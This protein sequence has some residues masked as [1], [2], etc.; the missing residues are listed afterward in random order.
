MA[1]DHTRRRRHLLFAGSLVALLLAAL[2]LPPLININR[3]QRQIT[4]SLA[5]SLGRPVEVSG[6]RLHLLPRPAVEIGNFIIDSTPGFGAEPILQ[7]SSVTADLRLTSLWRGRLEIARISLDEPS[8]N[9]ERASSGEWNFT[10]VLMQASRISQ[11]PTGRQLAVG[12]RRFPYIEASSARINF[13]YGNEKLPFSF[14]NADVSIWL[15]RPDEWQLR[16]AAQPVRTDIHLSLA[17]TGLVQLTGS[18]RRASS[19]A[20]LPLDL[21]LEWRKAPLGQVSRML[22]AQDLGWRGD[23]GVRA[24]ITGTPQSL[25]LDAS[26]AANDFHRESF[27]P[28]HPMNLHVRCTAT[29][30]HAVGALEG[31]NCL[32]PVGDG[33]LD[34]SGS[35][36]QLHMASPV[37]D[38]KLTASH[39]PAAAALQ[40]LRHTRGRLSDTITLDGTI[41][42]LLIYG[43]PPPRMGMRAGGAAHGIASGGLLATKLILH[44]DDFEQPLPDLRFTL[45]PSTPATLLLQPARLELGAPQPLLAD[46]RLNAQGFQLHYSG[47]A[48]LARLLP[49]TRAFGVLP[50]AFHGLGDTGV[51]DY[52]LTLQGPW[53]P[54]LTDGETPAPA[55]ATSG[56]LSLRDVDFQPDYLPAPVHIVTATATVAPDELRWTGIAATLGDTRFSGSLRMPLP[57]RS[58]CVRHFDLS[59][60]DTNMGELTALLRGD[61]QGVMRELISRVRTQNHTWPALEGSLH[62]GRLGLGRIVINGAVADLTA[63]KGRLEMR[64][65]DGRVLGG[66]VHLTGAA[67]LDA[68]PSYRIKLQFAHIS[69]PELSQLMAEHW[70]P[71]LLDI[72]GNL[73]LSGTTPADLSSSA[74]GT[75]HWEWTNGALPLLTTSPLRRFDRWTG[76]GKVAKGSLTLTESRIVSNGVAVPVTGTI[77]SDRSLDLQ[78]GSSGTSAPG[79]AVTGSLVAPVAEARSRSSE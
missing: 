67:T 56:S 1:A 30:R 12:Q 52:N 26:A 46:A 24:H 4:A 20:G 49:L 32:S 75:L 59:A 71:G 2:V 37:P 39:V 40:L 41:D 51:T 64:A 77:G 78:T 10:S 48:A 42:G 11:A 25:T 35:W 45:Q 79:A 76:D 21:D 53:A 63:A 3:Y 55:S 16:F 47:G 19:V 62:V 15:E 27:E 68:T 57:C 28:A 70:G 69:A 23:T 33:S 50:A 6:V 74:K 43:M 13:K 65:F 73:A 5:A 9:L 66:A 8:L 58:A 54:P 61:D 72:S 22:L 36:K 31:I 29:Y 14:L 17:D 60:A 18:V 7:C 38:L 44:G 34:L